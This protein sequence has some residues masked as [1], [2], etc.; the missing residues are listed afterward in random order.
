MNT[1]A[2]LLLIAILVLTTMSFSSCLVRYSVHRKWTHHRS[3]YY[4]YPHHGLAG[5]HLWVR[6]KYVN[7]H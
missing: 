4:Y 5:R 1:P 6:N 3:R 7:T 2:K